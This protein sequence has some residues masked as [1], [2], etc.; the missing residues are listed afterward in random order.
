MQ[1]NNS[2][3]DVSRLTAHIKGML[4]TNFQ[5]VHVLGEISNFKQ[6]SSGHRYFTLK[7]KQ[8][9]LQCVMWRSTPLRFQPTDGMKVVLVGDIT[10]YPPRG[11]YQLTVRSMKEHS[12]GDLLKA[13]EELKKKLEAKGYFEESR[14]RHLPQFPTK[15][16]V[17]TSATGAAIRDILSTLKRRWPLA[18]VVI[19]PT[20]VQGDAAAPDIASAI[21][22]LDA[23]QCDVLIV[24]RGGGSMEDLWAYNEEEVCDAVF[25]ASTPIV[26]AVGHETDITL[27]DF[28]A[29]V[30]AATPTGAAELVT[31][32]AADISAYLQQSRTRSHHIMHRTINEAAMR[33]DDISGAR[34]LGTL[35]E[36][37]ESVQST[38]E[39]YQSRCFRKLH[40]TVT[41]ER[42][43][44]NTLMRT[45]QLADP[46]R[47]LHRGYAMLYHK[48]AAVGVEQVFQTEDTVE[49]VTAKQRMRAVISETT[50]K[51]DTREKDI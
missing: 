8:A 18:E 33:L 19:R 29:D 15:I 31:P 39:S 11:N 21:R 5:G 4:E 49:I 36:Y 14:K 44:L 7:D 23:L 13:L 2:I 6:H 28:I 48:G 35:A 50:P 27:V 17:S 16:G 41:D 42:R 26:S 46:E 1:Q 25:Q 38:L 37:I 10:V 51:E 32:N 34:G 22:E 43:H 12:A 40:A 24:G 30:R 9:S 20:V 45:M 3:L 47:P